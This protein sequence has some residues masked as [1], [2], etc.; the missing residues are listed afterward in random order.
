MAM[1][2]L[3]GYASGYTKL[4]HKICLNVHF[5]LVSVLTKNWQNSFCHNNSEAIQGSK[6]MRFTFMEDVET[7]GQLGQK[8]VATHDPH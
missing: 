5:S 2:V 4:L 7:F 6:R 3:F 1:E 8:D